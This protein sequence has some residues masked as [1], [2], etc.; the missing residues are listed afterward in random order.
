MSAEHHA[1]LPAPPLEAIT[2]EREVALARQQAS[3]ARR[4]AAAI[5][6]YAAAERWY[7]RERA[8]DGQIALRERRAV[9]KA[10]P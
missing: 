8:L 2:N 10:R 1:E 6:D 4:H 9:A 3:D 5:G 7:D